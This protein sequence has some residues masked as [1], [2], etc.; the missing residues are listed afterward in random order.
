MEQ[1]RGP[2]QRDA[3]VF[4]RW[5]SS[6]E[7]GS[8]RLGGEGN[9]FLE[10]I[11]DIILC[12][13]DCEDCHV[14]WAWVEWK[15]STNRLFSSFFI[16]FSYDHLGPLKGAKLTDISGNWIAN[17]S[18]G[19]RCMTAVLPHG[20]PSAESVTLPCRKRPCKGGNIIKGCHPG[21]R[22]VQISI[23]HDILPGIWVEG[24]LPLRPPPPSIPL[25]NCQKHTEQCLQHSHCN[26]RFVNFQVVRW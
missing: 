10:E 16:E 24:F 8:G 12:S 19:T 21:L 9:G 14:S 1:E 6:C 7:L 22:L 2:Q 17:L 11:S 15:Q 25:A 4:F 3:A 13:I 23:F 20:R 26:K 5:R 18:R